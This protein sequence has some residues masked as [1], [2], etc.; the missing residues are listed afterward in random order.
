MALSLLINLYGSVISC[1]YIPGHRD[2]ECSSTIQK[3][4]EHVFVQN[5]MTVQFSPHSVSNVDLQ[6]IL[7][8]FEWGEP[9]NESFWQENDQHRMCRVPPKPQF[10]ETA[11][12]KV[13]DDY[14]QPAD[15]SEVSWSKSS[16]CPDT[17][18]WNGLM[19]TTGGKRLRGFSFVP[20]VDR[21]INAWQYARHS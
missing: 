3:P 9:L 7:W 12:V 16:L 21:G 13:L 14:E 20:A 1:V 6:F 2:E 4:V 15:S 18:D 19:R 11:L 10:S 5:L 17:N 8:V